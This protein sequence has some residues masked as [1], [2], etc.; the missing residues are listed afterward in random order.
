METI[1]KEQNHD[2][3]IY[4]LS[5]FKPMNRDDS[6]SIGGYN[7]TVC[8][9]HF[10]A[11]TQQLIVHC[12]VESFCDEYETENTVSPRYDPKY[13]PPFR[14]GRKQGRAVLDANGK[15]VVF[16]NDSEIQAQKY[17]DYLNGND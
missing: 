1:F 3:V 8:G 11:V 6:I 14:V 15:E 9:N 16:F 7:Y 4:K 2:K 12:E 13:T 10:E 5:G 17:C